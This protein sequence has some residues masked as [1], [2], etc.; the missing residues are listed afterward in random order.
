ME[1]DLETGMI[2]IKLPKELK[3]QY[4]KQCI[5]RDITMKDELIS[6]IKK[7]VK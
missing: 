1:Q 2:L 7:V 6:H 5:D 4:Q 3:R